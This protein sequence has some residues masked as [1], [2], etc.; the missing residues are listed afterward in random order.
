MLRVDQ[1]HFCIENTCIIA[2]GFKPRIRKHN[3]EVIPHIWFKLAQ[4][5]MLDLVGNNF[6]VLISSGYG[7][8]QLKLESYELLKC[9][10]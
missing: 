9:H 2:F 5:P 6:K 3:P 7:Y 4:M 8:H 1:N 10:L